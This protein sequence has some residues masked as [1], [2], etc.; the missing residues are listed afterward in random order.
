MSL[1]TCSVIRFKAAKS[2]NNLTSRVLFV[3]IRRK[4]HTGIFKLFNYK[5][6]LSSQTP[7]SE[8]NSESV[9][10]E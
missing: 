8:S 10:N 9:L 2:V 7:K 3:N 1:L 5:H 6:I 4:M